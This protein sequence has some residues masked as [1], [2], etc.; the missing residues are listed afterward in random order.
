MRCEKSFKK[1]IVRRCKAAKKF[2]LQLTAFVISPGVLD[3][4]SEGSLLVQV[5]LLFFCVKRTSSA[6]QLHE[7]WC[8]NYIL[9][10]F[11]YN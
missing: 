3:V 9:P 8:N 4:H 6:S 1:L 7:E 2:R 11:A 5:F 10:R